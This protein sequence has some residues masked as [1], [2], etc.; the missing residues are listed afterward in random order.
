MNAEVLE[1]VARTLETISVR[2][3][4]DCDRMA[5]CIKAVEAVSYSL[6][7]AVK[8]KHQSENNSVMVKSEG[9]DG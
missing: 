8:E 7:K 3:K 6:R 9:T 5:G 2:G 1:A 4:D